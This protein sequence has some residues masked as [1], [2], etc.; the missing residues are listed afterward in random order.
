ML[1]AAYVSHR[2]PNRLRIKIPSKKGDSVYFTYLKNHLSV[3]QGIEKTEINPITGSVLVVHTLDE[4]KIVTHAEDNKLFKISNLR[5]SS[6]GLSESILQTFRDLNA[7]ITTSTKGFANIPDIIFLTLLGVGIYQISRGNF[8]APA[9]YVAFWYAL[10]M[11][12][13]SQTQ[14]V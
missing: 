13:K 12:W 6:T 8:T 11:F 9:W 5:T 3:Y 4:R 14:R 2:T 1:P 10:N 7:K